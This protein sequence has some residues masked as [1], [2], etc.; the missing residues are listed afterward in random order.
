MTS[1]SDLVAL[2]DSFPSTQ[3]T[4]LTAAAQAARAE[5]KAT[6]TLG[7]PMT[8][9]MTTSNYYFMNKSDVHHLIWS[10]K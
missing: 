1:I 3:Q 9:T 8:M 7:L 2:L 10:G 6:H 5:V 4:R